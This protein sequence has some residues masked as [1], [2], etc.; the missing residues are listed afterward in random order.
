MDAVAL[1]TALYIGV[2]IG[3]YSD[4]I[5]KDL[6]PKPKAEQQEIKDGTTSSTQK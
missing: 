3:V 5:K 4:D 2:W 6:T 1:L